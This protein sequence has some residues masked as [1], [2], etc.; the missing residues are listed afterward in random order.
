VTAQTAAAGGFVSLFDG[1]SLAGWEYV[2]DTVG[3]S[4]EEG[5]LVCSGEGRGWL[6]TA[7]MYGDFVLHLEY[8]ISEGGNSGV[9]LRS[10]LEGRPAYDGM[11]MQIL[12]DHGA[13]AT[14]SSTGAIYDAVAPTKNAARPA[15][16]WNDLEITCAGSRVGFVLN[17]EH[18]VEVDLSADESLRGRPL[19]G[20]IGLQN[21]HS[22]VR[23]RSVLIQEL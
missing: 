16:Q 22:A 5:V 6:R 15:G 18:I 9:F 21:H 11:E 20:Y 2:R 14:V 13:P 17:G 3:W 10:L 8:A 19:E 12:D 1:K 4:A 23:F 7:R